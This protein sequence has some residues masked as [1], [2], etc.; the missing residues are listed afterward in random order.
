M[1]PYSYKRNLSSQSK[2]METRRV[3]NVE[4][5]VFPEIIEQIYEQLQSEI[6]SRAFTYSIRRDRHGVARRGSTRASAAALRGTLGS[7]ST[8]PEGADGRA[9]SSSG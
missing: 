3:K 4:I 9:G 7:E 5:I 1:K 6:R 2:I 8:G